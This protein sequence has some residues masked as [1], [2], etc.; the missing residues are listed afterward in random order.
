MK[1]SNYSIPYPILG[2]EGAFNE[3]VLLKKEVSFESTKENYIFKVNLMIYP[4]E[5]SF[6]LE[7]VIEQIKSKFTLKSFDFFDQ[8]I[9]TSL[10]RLLFC[11]LSKNFDLKSLMKFPRYKSFL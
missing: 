4:T 5:Y 8:V 9:C 7:I 10:E 3:N 2:I 6:I 1:L 11:F